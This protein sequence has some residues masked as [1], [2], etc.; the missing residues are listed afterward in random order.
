MPSNKGILLVAL[1]AAI[2]GAAA[3]LYFEPT[4]AQRL[5]GTE[6]GQRVLGAV[7]DAQAPAVPAGVKIAKRGDIVPT[8]TLATVDGTKTDIPAAWAGK[9]TLINLWASWCAPCLKEMPELQAFA[10]EKGSN[11]TQVVGIALDDATST[12]AMLQRLG[13]TY[14]NL[15]DTPGPADAGVRL[16]NPAG[17]LPYSVL[18]SADGRVLKT[19][20]GPF[21]DQQDIADWADA[22]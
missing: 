20:I 18:V 13:I 19:K 16:G 6:P 7:L 9:P 11:G 3:S 12:Q 1:L 5:A 2:A 22:N 14:P 21:D 15:I 4:I 8:M 17:V 10:A